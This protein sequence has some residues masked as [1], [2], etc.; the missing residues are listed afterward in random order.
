MRVFQ[1]ICYISVWLLATWGVLFTGRI[2]VE[3]FVCLNATSLR[4]IRDVDVRLLTLQMFAW[5]E[6][7]WS[8]SREPRGHNLPFRTKIIFTPELLMW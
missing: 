4:H 6:S 1:E 2:N 8:A 3:W 7:E 5:D